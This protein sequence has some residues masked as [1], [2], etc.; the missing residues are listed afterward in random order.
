[1]C[2]FSA[3]PAAHRA[4]PERGELWGESPAT[5]RATSA[6]NSPGSHGV[7]RRRD[8]P[9]DPSNSLRLEVRFFLLFDLLVPFVDVLRL[10]AAQQVIGRREELVLLAVDVRLNGVLQPLEQLEPAVRVRAAALEL[11]EIRF[12]FFVLAQAV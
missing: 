1:P 8:D 4:G 12:D 2:G 11:L 6:G 10:L 3:R 7:T 9:A 5:A